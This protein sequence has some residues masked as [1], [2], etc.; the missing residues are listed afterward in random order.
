[1]RSAIF[2]SVIVLAAC[3]TTPPA[4]IAPESAGVAPVVETPDASLPDFKPETAAAC[5]AVALR[6][7][8]AANGALT[9]NGQPADSEGL[10]AAAERKNAACLNAPAMVF[11]NAP[12]N[13]P[14]ATREATLNTLGQIIVNIGVIETNN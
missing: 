8:L 4:E 2:A 6:V 3:S 7:G 5:N 14:A 11:F 12:P 10:K 1:M 13:V 9:V